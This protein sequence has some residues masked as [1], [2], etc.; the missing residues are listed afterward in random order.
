MPTFS[1]VFN[2]NLILKNLPEALQHIA[3]KFQ[4]NEYGILIVESA[5]K[6]ARLS[7][8]HCW[9]LT[10][11]ITQ[12]SSGDSDAED[13]VT[14]PLTK[15]PTLVLE[16]YRPVHSSQEK[17]TK[18]SAIQA[19]AEAQNAAKRFAAHIEGL[20]QTTSACRIENWFRCMLRLAVCS[21]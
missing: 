1:W 17:D 7:F 6:T 21:L 8:L 20:R 4:V 12:E 18:G 15:R 13:P 9:S 14:D 19:T 11:T 16:L 10:I 5:H 3:W 2:L